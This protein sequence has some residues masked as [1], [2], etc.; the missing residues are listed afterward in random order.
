MSGQ[1]TEHRATSS[2]ESAGEVKVL[3]E[4][5]LLVAHILRP[6]LCKCCSLCPSEAPN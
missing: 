3:F 5:I 6:W 4:A 2:N 1:L